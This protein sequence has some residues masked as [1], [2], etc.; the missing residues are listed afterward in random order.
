MTEQSEISIA[1]EIPHSTMKSIKELSPN[2]LAQLGFCRLLRKTSTGAIEFG[3]ISIVD[4]FHENFTV[5]DPQSFQT[6]HYDSVEELLEDGW[7]E[8]L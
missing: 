2:N 8:K 3:K 1:A 6:W 7:V 4:I 5:I